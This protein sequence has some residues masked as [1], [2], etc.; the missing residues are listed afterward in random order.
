MTHKIFKKA[1]LFVLTMLFIE[2]ASAQTVEP[3]RPKSPM[4]NSELKNI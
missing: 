1:L 4:K 2:L 3:A